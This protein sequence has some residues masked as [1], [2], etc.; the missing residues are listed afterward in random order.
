M[1]APTALS[2][3]TAA[4]TITAHGTPATQGS[5][6]RSRWGM[7]DDNAKTLKPWRKIVTA[8]AQAARDAA[9][10][11]TLAGPLTVE[12]TVTVSKPKGAPKRRITWPIARGKGDIDKFQ[13]SA[14]DALTDAGVWGDDVQVVEVTARKVY[15]GEGIDALDRPGMVLHVWQLPDPAE[16]VAR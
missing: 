9:G 13:R 3:R 15:P 12:M 14:F 5:K 4:L 8:A 1:T 6:T 7:Y 16:V 11:D 2:P 10:L